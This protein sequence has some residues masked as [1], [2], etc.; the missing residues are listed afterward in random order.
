[1]VSTGHWFSRGCQLAA[2][3]VSFGERTSAGSAEE[4]LDT[5]SRWGQAR[6]VNRMQ[7]SP[8]GVNRMTGSPLRRPTGLEAK[9]SGECNRMDVAL[10]GP[11]GGYLP[12]TRR[13]TA[14]RTLK[15]KKTHTDT[16]EDSCVTTCTTPCADTDT[17][18]HATARLD[19]SLPSFLPSSLPFSFLLPPFLPSS[20][21][22]FLPSSFL[23]PPSSFLL[24]PSSFL[25]PPSSFLLSPFSFLLSPFSFLVPLPLPL[26]FN[27]HFFIDH[28]H[29]ASS[30][31]FSFCRLASLYVVHLLSSP[32]YRC[33]FL[34]SFHLFLDG[35]AF[36]V[37]FFQA[38]FLRN[39]CF[40]RL[41]AI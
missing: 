19:S 13:H 18:A 39:V 16:T 4:V 5:L 32:K 3:F 30:H 11:G 2:W 23:L 25:L 33:V 6:G 41:E 38:C 24:P 1:M 7:D 35:L 34:F 9:R 29:F 22:P 27:T 8:N 20:L 36:L 17:H 15:D 12:Q 31:L 10:L 37:V 26:P 14:P 28:F 40:Y 21:P